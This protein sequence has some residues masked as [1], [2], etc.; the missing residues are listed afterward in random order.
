MGSPREHVD[1]LHACERLEPR[2]A[3]SAAAEWLGVLEQL[4]GE[5]LAVVEHAGSTV[6][7]Y[8]D[9]WVVAAADGLSGVMPP[10]CGEG[11]AIDVRSLGDGHYRLDIEGI[12]GHELAAWAGEF[13]ATIEPDLLVAAQWLS[14]DPRL[15]SQ[16]ALNNVGQTAGTPDADIDAPEAWEITTG[17]HDVVVGVID[18]GIDLTHPD[19]AANIWRNPAEIPGNGIDDDH[20]G[21]IDDVH[22]WDFYDNDND[23]TDG[24]GHG[25]HVA[26]TIGAVGN[27][28][29]GIS[30]VSQ[31]VGLLPLKFLG[32]HGFGSTSGAI[33]A[34]N[35]AT[36]L[37]TEAGVNIVA[38][39]NSYSG[40]TNSALLI[41]AIAR[42]GEAGI[43]FVAA[44]GNAGGD[45]DL[46]P[47]FP[48]CCELPAVISVAATDHNDTLAS[49]SNYGGVSVDL[50]APGVMITS[51]LPGGRYAAMCGTS[52]AAPH[53]SGTVALLHAARP[54]LTLAE[55]REAI[56]TT[57]DPL[58]G[59][60]GRVASGGRLN[61][62]AAVAAVVPPP[63]E[64]GLPYTETFARGD[65]LFTSGPWETLCGEFCIAGGEA[66]PRGYNPSMMT[67][68][69]IIAADVSLEAEV[70]LPAI[71]SHAG[72]VGRVTTEGYYLGS[73]LRTADGVTGQI[74]RNLNGRWSRLAIG[75]A[76]AAAGTLRLD[77]AGSRIT[78]SLN[79]TVITTSTDTSLPAAG[80]VG[81]RGHDAA[82]IR[83]FTAGA[84]TTLGGP[85]PPAVPTPFDPFAASP[86]SIRLRPRPAAAGSLAPA[87]TATASGI[88]DNSFAI[89]AV[90]SLE[91]T[92]AP[93]WSGPRVVVG[94]ADSAALAV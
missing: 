51:T 3:L 88:S 9:R 11:R 26:G 24:H 19:L 71:A 29:R 42:G 79:G 60:S 54:G 87:A 32:D 23:P 12:A 49:F 30:G 50:A 92:A 20:N 72:L 36:M 82:V 91:R 43:S 63:A 93:V 4:I 33:A 31:Q 52:M 75:G 56:L 68:R 40:C 38:T 59:L 7:A 94:L 44:A 74:W 6:V 28:A 34:I 2:L 67:L 77:L 62:A 85:V 89:L 17:S 10:D 39:N 57:V 35:Y 86:I 48:S 70:D 5:D 55:V 1:K 73:L 46:V 58:P 65:E 15:L 66:V 14:N 13:E 80:G 61:A 83:Q 27:N 45:N 69:G 78:L 53:V 90:G 76:T 41:D 16:W 84:F 47:R 22:G 81:L 8:A 21:F 18:T 37:R 64:V 25:T